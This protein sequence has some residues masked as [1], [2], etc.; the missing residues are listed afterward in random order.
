MLRI[1]GRNTSSNVQKVL[2]ACTDMGLPFEREDIGGPFGRNR[3]PEYLA[4]NPNGLVPT[5]I[6]EDGW[7]LWESNA[8]TRYLAAK[9]AR[10]TLYPNDPRELASAERWMDWQLSVLNPG[11]VPVFWG[12]IRTPEAERD[13]DAIKAGRDRWSAAYKILDGFL[14]DNEF[15]SGGSF[16][17]G[18]IPVGVLT[19]RWFAL[20]I[21][22]EDYPHLAR[23]YGELQKRPG[24]REHV[25]RPL[26]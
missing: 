21:E 13:W 24:F 19:Y 2:W 12:L 18:D 15:C 23:W 11:M 25:N 14:A 26:A 3:D 1:L 8:A 5:I 7:H 20:P 16:S 9:H 6:E 4:L 22:R 10:G 17:V